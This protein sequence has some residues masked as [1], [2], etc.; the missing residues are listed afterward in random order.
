MTI[1]RQHTGGD[2]K[3]G[4][5]VGFSSNSDMNYQ[6]LQ[7]KQV[8]MTTTQAPHPLQAELEKAEVRVK[9]LTEEAES[10]GHQIYLKN[11]FLK[12]AKKDM[13]TI[14]TAMGKEPVK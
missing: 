3:E 5:Q 1:T 4:T 6:E 9:T 8:V 7:T 13:N 12:S 2:K 14:L 10:L 11:A